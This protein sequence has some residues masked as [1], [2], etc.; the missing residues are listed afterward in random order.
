MKKNLPWIFGGIVVMLLTLVTHSNAM[1]Q[2]G[3]T[4]KGNV[5]LK[6]FIVFASY[7]IA[8]FIVSKT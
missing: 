1:A 2:G 4:I 3:V 7:T 6:S 8:I 5:S